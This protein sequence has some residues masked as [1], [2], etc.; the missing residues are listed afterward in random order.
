MRSLLRFLPVLL[1]FVIRFV[2]SR[3]KGGSTG[4]AAPRG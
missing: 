1:P 2:K 3:R 4:P